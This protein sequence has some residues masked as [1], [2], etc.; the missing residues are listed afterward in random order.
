ML[1]VAVL[2][3]VFL[4]VPTSSYCHHANE[5]LLDM[6][7]NLPSANPRNFPRF[8]QPN[9][10]ASSNDYCPTR[11]PVSPF[12]RQH[13]NVQ[14]LCPWN[15]TLNHDENRYPHDI[16]EAQCTCGT[17]LNGLHRC[18]PVYHEVPV[19]RQTCVGSIYIYSWHMEMISVGCA[20]SHPQARGKRKRFY[21]V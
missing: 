13:V 2:V 7:R 8:G 10:R 21:F 18:L 19:I 1:V 14:S 4:A 9:I 11:P 6:F 16:L 15:Y 17:C 5:E 20:C 3:V 12:N